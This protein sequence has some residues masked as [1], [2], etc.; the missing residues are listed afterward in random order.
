MLRSVKGQTLK[1]TKGREMKPRDRVLATLSH[2]EPDRVPIWC[3]ASDEFW[4]KAKLDAVHGEFE[5]RQM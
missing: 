3:G 5:R 1:M 2:E 4:A